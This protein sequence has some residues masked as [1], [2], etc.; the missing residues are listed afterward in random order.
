M[1]GIV[2]LLQFS[3]LSA[4]VLNIL[5]LIGHPQSGW[6]GRTAIHPGVPLSGHYHERRGPTEEGNYTAISNSKWQWVSNPI[7]IHPPPQRL[8]LTTQD[9]AVSVGCWL[10]RCH[11]HQ[12]FEALLNRMNG[13]RPLRT[14]IILSI[15]NIRCISLFIKDYRKLCEHLQYQINKIWKYISWWI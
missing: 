2:P 6:N 14:C 12:G 1:E 11:K 9:S 4:R 8:T 3:L 7:P 10:L 13:A 5:Y 15:P